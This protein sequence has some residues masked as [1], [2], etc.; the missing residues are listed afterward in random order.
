MSQSFEDVVP[1][2]RYNLR[3]EAEIARGFL[4][5]AGIESFVRADDGGGAFGVPL[6]YTMDSFAE[7]F[8]AAE[9]AERAR[10]ILRDAGFDGAQTDE[11]EETEDPS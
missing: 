3:H 8:V 10:G 11:E 9:D 1:V 6:S 4:E 2:A 7:I 5:E